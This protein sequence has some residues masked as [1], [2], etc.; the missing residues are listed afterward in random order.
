MTNRKYCI[1]NVKN[2]TEIMKNTLF[3]RSKQYNPNFSVSISKPLDIACNKTLLLAIKSS[4]HPRI[5]AVDETLSKNHLV[6]FLS[7]V[8]PDPVLRISIPKPYNRLKSFWIFCFRAATA[9]SYSAER[10]CHL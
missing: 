3:A 7:L 4:F 2:K 9:C 1:N 10:A 8:I 5:S 6:V